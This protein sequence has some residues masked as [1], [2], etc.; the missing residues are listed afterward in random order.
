MAVAQHVNLHVAGIRSTQPVPAEVLPDNT[1]RASATPGMVTGLA[2]GDVFRII[3]RASGRVEVVERGGTLGLQIFCATSIEA[4]AKWLSPR[5]EAI[6][7]CWDGQIDVAVVFTV[8]FGRGF[9]PIEALIAELCTRFQGI[10]WLYSNV[11]GDDGKPLN[12]WVPT[13]QS[14][15]A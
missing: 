15:V 9:E 4:A 10:E 12:W 2:A 6:G 5:I 7:G 13:L 14:R 11:Y 1:Y 8:P 3:D